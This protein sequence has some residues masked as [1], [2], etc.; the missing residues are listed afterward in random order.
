MRL[1]NGELRRVENLFQEKHDTLTTL[2]EKLV[3]AP[4]LA[5]PRSKECLTLDVHGC[6]KKIGWAMVQVQPFGTKRHSVIAQERVYRQRI[7]TVF[8]NSFGC[9]VIRVIFVETHFHL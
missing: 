7:T 3:S 6:D 9:S 2:Q 5:L 4:V 8:Q 1:K